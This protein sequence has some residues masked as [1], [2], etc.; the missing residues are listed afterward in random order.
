MFDLSGKIALVTGATG[1]IGS[2]IASTLHKMGAVVAISGTKAGILKDLSEKLSE[3]VYSFTCDFNDL[4]STDDLL[5][6]IEQQCGSVNI[7]VN[8]AGLTRDNVLMRISNED[9]SKV[10]TVNLEVPFRLMRAVSRNM[11]KERWGRIINISSIVGSVGNPGQ[12]NYA[13]SKSGLLGLTKTAAVE[14]ATRDITVNCIAPGFICSPMTEKIPDS[15]REQ[16][17]KNIPMSRAGRPEEVAA[18]VGFLASNEASYIT[19][20]VLHVNGGLAMI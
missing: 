17:I 15:R 5:R 18:A 14:L 19:G 2:V 6:R 7:L 20:H 3:R 13:A 16:L 8:N 10:I 12:A 9:W 11:I 4:D 1:A